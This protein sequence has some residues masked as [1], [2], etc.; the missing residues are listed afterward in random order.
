[1]TQGF[2]GSFPLAAAD[3]I[4]SDRKASG[5]AGGSAS[6][7]VWQTRGL[8]T[9]D[10]DPF[11]LCTLGT[12]QF[13]LTD[14]HWQAWGWALGNSVNTHQARIFDVSASSNMVIGGSAYSPATGGMPTLS[15]IGGYFLSISSHWLELQHKCAAALSTF[16]FGIPCGNDGECYAQLFLKRVLP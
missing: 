9:K 12:N 3:V 1:M 10:F 2:I 6:A 14:G 11:N 13:Q 7:G 16:A 4:L 15:M 8:A 5:T